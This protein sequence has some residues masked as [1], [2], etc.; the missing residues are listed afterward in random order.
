[1]LNYEPARGTH[2]SRAAS[3]SYIPVASEGILLFC[4]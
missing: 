4:R 3:A 2:M 1:L